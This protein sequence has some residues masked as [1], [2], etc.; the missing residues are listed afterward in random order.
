METSADSVVRKKSIS[1]KYTSK[2]VLSGHMYSTI[3][4]EPQFLQY[5]QEHLLQVTMPALKQVW[6]C[7]TI[8]EHAIQEQKLF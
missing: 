2:L 6:P 8:N 7:K 4:I 1:S 5:N 3:F